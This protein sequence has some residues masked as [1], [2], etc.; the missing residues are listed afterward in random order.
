MNEET[1]TP[2]EQMLAQVSLAEGIYAML[3]AGG[4]SDY[5]RQLAYANADEHMRKAERWAAIAQ[6]E[7]AERSATA[8]ERIASLLDGAIVN[9]QDGEKALQILDY[10]TSLRQSA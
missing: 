1:V 5:N 2:L 7:A 8:L 6:A 4:G 9:V 3:N 10:F